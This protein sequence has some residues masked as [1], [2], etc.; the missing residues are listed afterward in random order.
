[1]SEV[2]SLEEGEFEKEEEDE[3]PLGVGSIFY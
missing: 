1:M 3:N 2:D